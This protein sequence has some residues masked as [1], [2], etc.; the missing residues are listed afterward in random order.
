[1]VRLNHGPAGTCE[2]SPPFQRWG[3]RTGRKLVPQGTAEDRN[4][5]IGSALSPLPG[6]AVLRGSYPTVETVGYFLN[7]PHE[8]D[9]ANPVALAFTGLNRT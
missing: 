3:K 9:A 1:M 8:L 6:L 2:N 5:R 4:A 7:P